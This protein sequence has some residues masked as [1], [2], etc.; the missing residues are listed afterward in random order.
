MVL[1]LHTATIPITLSV[2]LRLLL[3]LLSLLRLLM[4]LLFLAGFEF[5]GLL[6]HFANG[7]A[8]GMKLSTLR[9][10]VPMFRKVP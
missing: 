7:A 9:V 1:L 2:F 4:P 8:R 10:L 6:F 3:I 5:E